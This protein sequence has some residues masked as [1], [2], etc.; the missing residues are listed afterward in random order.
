MYPAK[1]V[2]QWIQK[3]YTDKA[4]ISFSVLGI[5]KQIEEGAEEE[6]IRAYL[7]KLTDNSILDK[8]NENIYRYRR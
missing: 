2:E 4:I 6:L 8:D 5:K 1:T 7:D 3:N